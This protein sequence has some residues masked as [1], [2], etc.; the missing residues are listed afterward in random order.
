M[1]STFSPTLRLE[2]IGD[3]DQSGIW[4][5]TTNTNLGTLLEQSITG[6][7]SITMVDAN[8]TLTNF[9][10]VSDEA[11]NQVIVATGTNAAVRD[12]IA[13]LVEKTYTIQNSTTGGFGVRI[14]GATGTGVTIP[15]GNTLQVY[16]NGTNFLPST[17]AAPGNFSVISD[18][19]VSGNE[20]LQ[21]N[22]TVNGNENL[23]GNLTFTGTGK[24]ILGDFS[25]GTTA[26]RV[27]FQ[28][29]TANSVTVV[30]SVP[31]GSGAGSLFQAIGSSDTAN[32]ATF[33]LVCDTSTSY[34]ESN[35]SGTASYQPIAFRTSA[36]ERVRITTAGGISFGAT[37]TNFGTSGQI[38]TSAGDAPPTWTNPFPS[39]GI[40]MWS[41]S[42]AN[43]PSGWL[44]CNGS[45]GTPDLR[46]RFVVGAGSTYAVN[47]TGGATT[48]TLSTTNLPSH[49]HSISASGTTS[50][51]NID[52][53]HDISRF[54]D[55][56]GTSNDHAHG[57]SDPGHQ[58]SYR[59]DVDGR[60]VAFVGNAGDVGGL[61]LGEGTGPRG[62]ISTATQSSTTGIT[63][64]GGQ[65]AG[66][67]HTFTISGNSGAMNTNQTHTHTV[68]VTGT[69]GATGSGTAFSIL[70]PYF[71]L[72]FIMKS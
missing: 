47:A 36:T 56:G 18:L 45:S 1:A 59:L 21:G 65:N 32:S 48:V 14:I 16:C 19:F 57:I 67:T 12:I 34:L 66:H 8:Y 53:V 10:G 38:L 2:L 58:H 71:A 52:H 7:V 22:L 29:S 31:A 24:R 17:T 46:D 69:S 27:L 55:T 62:S 50:A 5:Q 28:T 60:N 9:N 35:K 4:G 42:I 44:L 63:G 40:I 3:G 72:A 68:T 6:V 11:R 33:S 23:A 37:G 43:I 30:G 64:T 70:P 25:N 13:P 39:G 15:N 20:T 54:G 41:G 26:N 51:T 61:T 49:T